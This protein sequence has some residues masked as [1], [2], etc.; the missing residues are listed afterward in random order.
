MTIDFAALLKE[1]G[2]GK[3]AARSL[4]V[5]QSQA[6]G[7]ALAANTV[8][9]GVLGGMLIALR[10]KGESAS[11]LLG[12]HRGLNGSP[13]TRPLHM[14]PSANKVTPLVIPSY[15]GAR[16]H[17]NLLPLLAL[18]LREL[19]IPVLIHGPRA[20]AGRTATIT[21]LE[22]LDYPP[23]RD[24]VD[25]QTQLEQAR[26][27]Y[28]PIDLLSPALTRLLAWRDI[29][30]VRNV[31]HTL[32][33][34][35]EPIDAPMLRL[36]GTTHTAYRDLLGEF[37]RATGGNAVLMRG[38]EGEA[39]A[40]PQRM[41][42]LDWIISGETS[43]LPALAASLSFDAALEALPGLD[44]ADTARW[45]RDILN[46]R[47]GPMIPR[48]LGE[49]AIRLVLISGRTTTLETARELVHQRFNLRPAP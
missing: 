30:G 42:A 5:E 31:G 39:V 21:I 16:R 40:S 47:D 38:H 22:M 32:V 24:L 19:D 15:N 23:A 8:P 46:H 9:D 18:M 7:S 28:V 41:P 1:I 14:T 11:E 43:A 6:L 3:H 12:L 26:L 33:K 44:A 49:Q 37:L 13:Q 4:N 34:L 45:I 17:P 48:A 25:A 20:V 27:A 36:I 10:M 35:L 29:L 2:R